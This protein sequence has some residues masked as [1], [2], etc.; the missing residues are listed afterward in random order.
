MPAEAKL[1]MEVPTQYAKKLMVLQ[2]LWYFLTFHAVFLSQGPLFLRC[3]T[4]LLKHH[5]KIEAIFV[6]KL[7]S[8][9]F[10]MLRQSSQDSSDSE[11]PLVNATFLLTQKPVFQAK[12]LWE[13]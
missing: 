5:S 8:A 6:P 2:I 13:V 11:T 12:H 9:L 4:L 10:D 3:H 1:L 7:N